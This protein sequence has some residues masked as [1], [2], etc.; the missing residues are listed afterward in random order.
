MGFRQDTKYLFN[1]VGLFLLKHMRQSKFFNI[2][3][4]HKPKM[5]VIAAKKFV[6][7]VQRFL[8]SKKTK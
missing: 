1:F 2:L 5:Y 8:D 4:K 3:K 6:S 7:G